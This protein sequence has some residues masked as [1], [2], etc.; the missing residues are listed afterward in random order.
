MSGSY[1]IPQNT[2]AVVVAFFIGWF[3]FHAQR[4]MAL[5]GSSQKVPSDFFMLVY[6]GL[7]H[8][9]G[10]LY[11]LS[12]CVNPILYHIM[13]NK[14][15]Q[16]FKDTMGHFCGRPSPS[17]HGH[18]TRTYSA[19]SY[20]HNRSLR[21]THYTSQRAMH[22]NKNPAIT[23][24]VKVDESNNIEKFPLDMNVLEHQGRS[25]RASC[26]VAHPNSNGNSNGM[27]VD[28]D[29]TTTYP[30]SCPVGDK[31]LMTTP[32]TATTIL[33]SSKSVVTRVHCP[34]CGGCA[35]LNG[36]GR[37]VTFGFLGKARHKNHASLFRN[38][39]NGLNNDHCGGS[40][41]DIATVTTPLNSSPPEKENQDDEIPMTEM[42]VSTKSN[43]KLNHSSKMSPLHLRL[44]SKSTK[45]KPSLRTFLRRKK[46]KSR[47]NCTSLT[48]SGSDYTSPSRNVTPFRLPSDP[49][50]PSSYAVTI[51]DASM[52]GG[53]HKSVLHH[54]RERTGSSGNV[55]GA[56]IPKNTCRATSYTSMDSAKSN[57]TNTISNSS[58]QDMDEV[59]YTSEELAGYMAELNLNIESPKNVQV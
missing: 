48:L 27:M 57:N 7:T 25:R 58:L 40:D 18:H 31:M 2:F 59:E 6:Q 12:T 24:G 15:R 11:Y 9:S 38:N 13:S 29:N 16:A 35:N 51:L 55:M 1:L 8:V 3:P 19:M 50:I 17:R 28:I 44:D 45:P 20:S 36:N 52:K 34:V 43:G 5:Y 23:R 39:G 56:S 54:P 47:D 49:S 33:S 32:K 14:F 53:H 41:N 10:I 46:G 42:K 22:L 21:M 26:S 4:L 30:C 37:G